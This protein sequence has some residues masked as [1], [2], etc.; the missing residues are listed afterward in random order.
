MSL[1]IKLRNRWSS[2]LINAIIT[3]TIGAILIF[4]PEVIYKTIVIGIGVLLFASGVGSLVYLFKTEQSKLKE[5]IFGYG[6]ALINIA[7]GIFLITKPL[8][9]V[10]FLVK[11]IAV[12]LVFIGIILLI[13]NPD[14]TTAIKGYSIM[15]IG[16][17]ASIIL[18]II[19]FFWPTFPIEVLGHII[20]II[21]LVLLYI[22]Y[23]T[24]KRGGHA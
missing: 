17:V 1:E 23:S 11:F 14:Q 15:F 9:V 12:W 21:G 10:S 19:L 5:Q 3:T 7:I 16:G 20:F 6:Q 24:Y 18:G 22:S 4:I 8:L 13:I 2:T